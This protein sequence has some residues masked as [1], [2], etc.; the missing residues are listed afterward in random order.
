MTN[1]RVIV[2]IGG[3]E[4]KAKTT[5]E[6]DE[7]IANLA[8]KR[9]GESRAVA[10]F[11]GTASH[12]SLP[13][14]NSFRKTYTS[15]FDVKADLALLTKKDIP[16]EHIKEKIE[17]ADMIYVGGGDTLYM[18]E[19][20][21]KTGMRE[22]ILDAYNRG[23]I[24]SGLSAGAICWF[25][26][27]YTDSEKISGGEYVVRDG[28]GVLKGIMTPHFNLREEFVEVSKNYLP[29]AY[30]VEDNSALVFVNEKLQGS[31]TSG[32]FAYTIE[33]GEKKE[34]PKL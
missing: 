11:I 24:I 2:A 30:A 5:R 25:E 23:V 33:N 12:D 21:E 26:K 14:F 27:I 18:L 16:M 10:L 3:G 7:Y 17:K 19:V 15:I 6:I 4:I 32:G 28:L 34:I 31:L 1:D 22:L 9:A 20:W 29:P 13:Y 8:K